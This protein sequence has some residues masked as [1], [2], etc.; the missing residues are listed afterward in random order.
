MNPC[1]DIDALLAPIS[2]DA[3][4]GADM[5]YTP[6]FAALLTAAAGKPAQQVGEAIVPAV[7][8][9]WPLVMRLGAELLEKTRDLR[10]A[11][12][13]TQALLHVQGLTGLRVGLVLIRHYVEDHWASLH[14]QL[15]P[16][17]GFD[18]AIRVNA[19]A[20][21]C[22]LGAIVHPLRDLPLLR[23]AMG[24]PISLNAIAH[25]NGSD[26][27]ANASA[28]PWPEPE[29]ITAAFD[30]AERAALQALA[31]DSQLAK[32]A[33]AAIERELGRHAGASQA[34][35]FD[36]LT[37]SLADIHAAASAALADRPEPAPP[38]APTIEVIAEE[39]AAPLP[40]M[41]APAAAAIPPGPLQSRADVLRGLDEMCRYFRQHEPSHPVPI[42]LTRARRWIEM[43]FMDLLRDL[44]PEAVGEAEKLRGASHAD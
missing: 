38:L 14:P 11:S 39:A 23:S 9:E 20:V 43:D 19:L 15:D 21:L 4:C 2:A 8:P 25:A 37:R 3:P 35:D 31:S 13:L 42:L 30:T 6:E 10:I 27:P 28:M 26:I 1:I 12:R 16:E 32:A 40:T 24:R 17:D 44:A 18:P 29:E 36:P 34:L 22:H 41:P 7:E 33:A 5:E